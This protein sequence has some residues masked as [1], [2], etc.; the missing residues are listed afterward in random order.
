MKLIRLA[1]ETAG[2]EHGS[3]YDSPAPNFY[4]TKSP[5]FETS[6][7][8]NLLKYGG[9]CHPPRRHQSIV[10]R[11]K[12]N[13]SRYTFHSILPR[14]EQLR[15]VRQRKPLFFFFFWGGAIVVRISHIYMAL[16]SLNVG[17]Y[18]LSST[19]AVWGRAPEEALTTKGDDCSILHTD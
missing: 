12:E 17:D 5:V 15:N 16:F 14:I 18:R 6:P 1:Y 8:P 7:R 10:L 3:F 9:L 13:V 19:T 2:V 11:E 4:L